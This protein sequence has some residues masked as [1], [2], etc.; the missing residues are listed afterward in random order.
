MLGGLAM[1]TCRSP[2]LRDPIFY[3]VLYSP[4]HRHARGLGIVNLRVDL[5]GHTSPL[6]VILLTA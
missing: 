3:L 5:W 4:P 1:P 2:D 6:R